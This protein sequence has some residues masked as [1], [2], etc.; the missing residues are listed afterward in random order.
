[1]DDFKMRQMKL[2]KAITLSKLRTIYNLNNI[3]PNGLLN[4]TAIK[5]INEL[6]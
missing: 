4:I 6:F 3:V 1:M 5:L 2:H